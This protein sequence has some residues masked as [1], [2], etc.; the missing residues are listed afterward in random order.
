ME[1]VYAA[2]IQQIGCGLVLPTLLV[3]AT[4]GLAYR[5]RGRGNGLWQ[6]AFGLG[7]FVSGA[8]LKL[9]GSLD[10]G[11][12]PSSNAWVDVPGSSKVAATNFTMSDTEPARFFRLRS[13]W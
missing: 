4:R 2:N 7:L 11:L 9:A 8:T 13:P 10:V 12:N 3:W 5:I 6:G 1:Y